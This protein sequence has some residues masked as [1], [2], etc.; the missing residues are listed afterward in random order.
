MAY[1]YYGNKQ[2]ILSLYS[3]IDVHIVV[4]AWDYM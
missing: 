2:A 4:S 3:N 1:P